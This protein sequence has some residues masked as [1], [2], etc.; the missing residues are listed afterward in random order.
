[1]VMIEGDSA[2]LTL[3]GDGITFGVGLIKDG[4]EWKA[5]RLFVPNDDIPSGTEVVEIGLAEF[6]FNGDLESPAV[7]SG[8]FAFHV[9]NEG[10]QPHELVLVALPEGR[11][12]EELVQDE[13]FQPEPIL[14]RTT[15]EPGDESDVALPAPLEPGRYGLVC[16]LPDTDDPEG[17]PHAFKG[18]VAEFTVE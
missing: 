12:I 11:P 13:S 8:D 14:V 1:T 6:A 4:D 18:M 17:T 9:T 10:Q 15:Y 16:F 7:T 3:E 5:D 2:T